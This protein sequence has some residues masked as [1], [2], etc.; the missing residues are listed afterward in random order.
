MENCY[1]FNFNKGSCKKFNKIGKLLVNRE[2]SRGNLFYLNIFYNTCMIA[3]NDNNFLWHKI[4]C[5]VN[6][7][8]IVN[9]EKKKCL[10]GLTP[11]TKP[12]NATCKDYQLGKLVS[13]RF[14]NKSLA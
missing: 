8:S 7:E 1:K 5:H 11:I 6:F 3:R 2:Q 10:R 4:L 13:S 14:L 9:V 12:N